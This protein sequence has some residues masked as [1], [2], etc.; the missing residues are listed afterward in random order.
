MRF[1]AKAKM[2]FYSLPVLEAERIRAL[3]RF[4]GN[5]CVAL[6]PCV[7]DGV[8]FA[9]VTSGSP[10]LRYGIE[11]DSYRAE[12]ARERCPPRCTATRLRLTVRLRAARC[13]ISIRRTTMS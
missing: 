8:A 2:G 1:V 4:A 13:F 5:S 7:G 12:Q 3:L 9:A 6:D 10:A 11:L